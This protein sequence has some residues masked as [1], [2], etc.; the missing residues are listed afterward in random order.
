MDKKNQKPILLALFFEN[1]VA[2]PRYC[3]SFAMF[4]G[5]ENKNVDFFVH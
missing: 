5:R 3:C 1:M 4:S 2:F